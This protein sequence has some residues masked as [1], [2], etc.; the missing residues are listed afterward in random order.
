MH[1]LDQVVNG[2]YF[3]TRQYYTKLY[4]IMTGRSFDRIKNY[5]KTILSMNAIY[6]EIMYI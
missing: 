4:T 5:W 1:N 6:R 3:S 2:F